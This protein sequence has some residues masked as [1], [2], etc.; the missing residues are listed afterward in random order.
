MGEA[1][2]AWGKGAWAEDEREEARERLTIDSGG[3][4]GAWP[5]I[6]GASNERFTYDRYMG[7]YCLA[8]N[9]AVCVMEGLLGTPLRLRLPNALDCL[10]FDK[11]LV[12]LQEQPC[13]ASESQQQW[14]YDEA[15]LVFRHA[16]DS[17]R[18]IDFLESRQVFGVWQCRDGQEINSQQQFRYHESV[19][20]FCLLSA[21]SR[22]LQEA[23]STLLY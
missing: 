9:P 8:A 22:C 6:R 5:C 17:T 2:E 23:T 13:N 7:R 15:T 14:A 12:T 1:G 10:H 4:L 16:A 3:A 20:R 19:D 11:R 18:C 21:P